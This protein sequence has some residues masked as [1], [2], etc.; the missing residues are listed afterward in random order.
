MAKGSQGYKRGLGQGRGG[1]EGGGN[2]EGGC[3]GCGRSRGRRR[4][5]VRQ[6]QRVQGVRLGDAL[7]DFQAFAR[8]PFPVALPFSSVSRRRY[9]PWGRTTYYSIPAPSLPSLPPVTYGRMIPPPPLRGEG[10]KLPTRPSPSLSPAPSPSP[11][12]PLRS[13]T[14]SHPCGK[15]PRSPSPSPALP[16][17]PPRPPLPLPDVSPPLR[18]HGSFPSPS[19]PFPVAS[20]PCSTTLATIAASLSPLPSHITPPP[21]PSPGL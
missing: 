10:G 2:V 19:L 20:P 6:G 15:M 4:T 8:A 14:S 11:P 16:S 21:L 3:P 17:L 7:P 5:E 13:L 12:P 1:A 9:A 18:Q